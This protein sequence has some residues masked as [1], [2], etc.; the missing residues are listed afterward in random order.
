LTFPLVAIIAAHNEGDVIGQV[1]ADLI[2]QGAHVYFMDDSSTDATV[3]AVEPFLGRGVLNIERLAD[4]VMT[5]SAAFEWE[6]ILLRKAQVASELDAAWFIHHDADEFRESPWPG[7]SL[8]AAI[9]R[10]DAA[11]FNAIDFELL[12]FWPTEETPEPSPDVRR[13]HVR[14]APGAPYDKVQIR[15]WKKT[16][17]IVD[18]ASSG[19]HEARFPGRNVFPLRFIV[20]HYPIRGRAHGERKIAER[21]ARFLDAERARG[22]HVQ[23]DDVR[24][25]GGFV[26]AASELASYEPETVRL[27]LALRH[28]GVEELEQALD[29]SRTQI[30]RLTAELAESRSEAAAH[31]ADAVAAQALADARSADA[32]A[33]RNEAGGVRELLHERINEVAALQHEL[34][35]RR[36]EIDGLKGAVA[37]GARQIDELHRSTSWRLTAPVRAAYRLLKRNGKSEP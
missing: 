8:A 27:A 16:S 14:Y 34:L 22:W 17:A 35:H 9:E 30:E 7:L 37:E 21:R 1:V 18:L 3:A 5:E 10:V 26:R 28:R 13:T 4:T 20:R 19:G 25:G 23:Y 36:A 12:N 33:A 2:E 6:R 29:R 31:A 11:G 24:E 15:C 32:D